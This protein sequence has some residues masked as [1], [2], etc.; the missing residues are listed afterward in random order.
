MVGKERAGIFRVWD[1]WGE[2]V[3][4]F[5]NIRFEVI[6]SRFRFYEATQKR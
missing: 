1:G 6:V 2:E 3:V 5:Y 4:P